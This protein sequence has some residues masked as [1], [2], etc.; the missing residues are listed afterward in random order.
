MTTVADT[1]TALK[2]DL[3]NYGNIDFDQDQIMHYM[4]RSVKI[5]DARLVAF[6]SDQTFTQTALTLPIS[7]NY[8]TCPAQTLAVREIWHNQI[9]K[10]NLPMN[11]LYYRRRFRTTQTAV[12]H[13]WTHVQDQ[14]QFEVTADQ[15][16]AMT[17]IY[18]KASDTLTAGGNMPY[19]GDYDNAIRET[20]VQM[21]IHKK[22]KVDSPTDAV[23]A[24]IFDQ[25]LTNDIVNRRFTRKLYKLD[26]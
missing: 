25:I 15:E 20:T 1:L 26:F 18:D 2:Y 10:T 11:E 24:Q 5:L 17:I 4:N 9:R 14:I 6:N 19:N 3:R 22:H 7:Q 23:Y 16:Y 12:P 21:C 13:F 8:A